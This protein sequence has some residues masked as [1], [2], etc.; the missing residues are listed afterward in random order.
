ME[1]LYFS[2]AVASVTSSLFFPVIP[3][4]LQVGIIVYAIAVALYLSTT[5][6]PIYKVKNLDGCSCSGVDY[7]V[8]LIIRVF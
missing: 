1:I 2:R 6:E 8:R 3:W 7:Q 5:G 4:L